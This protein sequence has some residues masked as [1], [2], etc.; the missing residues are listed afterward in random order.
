MN[1][2]TH[3]YSSSASRESVVPA[4]VAPI[5]TT[6]LRKQSWLLLILLAAAQFMVIIDATVVNVALPSIGSTAIRYAR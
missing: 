3:E 1:R 6:S 5:D 4:A 2:S